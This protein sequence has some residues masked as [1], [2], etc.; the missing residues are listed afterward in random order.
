MLA[1]IDDTLAGRYRTGLS[2]CS[3]GNLSSFRFLGLHCSL[4]KILQP[5]QRIEFLGFW[6]DLVNMI[7]FD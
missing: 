6:L 1:F 3:D 4:S 7:F 5:T 2:E